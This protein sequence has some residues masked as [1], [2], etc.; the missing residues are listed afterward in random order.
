MSQDLS[1]AEEHH[2]PRAPGWLRDLAGAWIFYSV[3]PA[4]P[5]P[6]P[7]F[8]RIAR[9]A[10]LI[11]LVLGG[12]QALLW[13]GTAGWL[14]LGAQV[15]LVLALALLLSGG[16]HH[17]GALDTADGLA[18]GPRALEAMA[19]SRVGAAA[20]QAALVL[21]LLRGT[22]L[23]C[24]AAAAP[25][26]LLWTA[27]WG[28]CAPLLAMAWFPYLRRQ[29][30]AGGTAGFHRQHWLGLRREL[31]PALIAGG[32]LVALSFR[33]A[34][35]GLHGSPLA[36]VAPLAL[37][38]LGGVPALVVPRWLGARLGGHSG[39]SYGACV[40][41]TEALGLLLMGLVLRALAVRG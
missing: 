13:L 40:E 3:L 35:P 6:T 1:T 29:P 36:P 41:W 19:D 14:P 34:L 4:W 24:L 2:Q 10:P 32:L 5:R 28:R 18:A 33:A 37:G 31:R 16:L 9:F 8:R 26:P 20:V 23:L 22:G 25:L 11:G 17:D 12:L 39:D 7:R 21:A 27:F 15:A 30:A 38:L